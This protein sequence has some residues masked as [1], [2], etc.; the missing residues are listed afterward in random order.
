[1]ETIRKR[2]FGEI[3]RCGPGSVIAIILLMILT[4]CGC[5]K[6]PRPDTTKFKV[7][8]LGY[9]SHYHV[10][11]L[12]LADG[13]FVRA[14]QD[15]TTS[16]NIS[17]YDAKCNLIGPKVYNCT[18][19]YL[20]D[21]MAFGDGFV[22]SG[23]LTLSPQFFVSIFDKN[24]NLVW[25]SVY[26]VPVSG[27]INSVRCSRATDGNIIV[28]ISENNPPT[29]TNSRPP[30]IAKVNTSTRGLSIQP[31]R[32][33]NVPT[34]LQC[35]VT[36]VFERSDGVYIS[37]YYFFL[38]PGDDY[39]L[40]SF[41]CMKANEEGTTQWFNSESKPP[42]DQSVIGNPYI[43][44]YNIAENASGPVTIV[45]TNSLQYILSSVDFIH[46]Y[47]YNLY[48]AISVMSYDPSTGNK[49]STRTF[50]IDHIAALPIIQTTSDG[51]IIAATGNNYINSGTSPTTA[52]LIKTDA[53]LNVQW[54]KKFDPRGS[55]FLSLGVFQS[56]DG[57]EITGQSS[58]IIE[59][60]A[61]I[62]TFFIKTDVRGNLKD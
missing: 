23:Y 9:I 22:L 51:F 8:T 36:S 31:H 7:S 47:F 12:Q 50:D 19:R 26:S 13:S 45:T 35:W 60:D 55:S 43:L 10:R 34:D 59:H 48:G 62:G 53:Q 27:D 58:S 4:I 6:T 40:G 30:F 42:I 5:K 52:L 18:E 46:G 16:I 54:Q 56:K 28:V 44:G 11:S 1:M 15:V 38:V 33:T 25:D 14:D 32:L 41:F 20:N 61:T 37:G 21:A 17:H 39:Y 24:C 3:L 29:D 57:Y 49:I 2:S